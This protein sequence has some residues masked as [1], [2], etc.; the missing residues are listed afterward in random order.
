[1]AGRDTRTRWQG[2]FARHRQGCA[3]EQLPRK[4][5][6]GDV[7][8]VCSCKP[9][10]Y[11]KVYDRAQRRYVT[12]KRCFT[13][14]AARSARKTLLD[15]LEKGE[16]PQEAPQRLRDAHARFIAAAEEGRALNKHGRRYKRSAWEDIDECLTK[17]V[18]PT[19]GP[20][21]LADVRRADIQRLVDD[22]TPKMSGSR[23]RSI[24]NAIRSLYRWAQ[25]REL[26]AHDPA[27]RVR[28]P[29]MN[30][31]PR[32]RVATPKEFQA[33]LAALEIDDAL[34]YALAGYGM[35][36]RAQIQHLRWRDV[37][38]RVGAIEWGNE[39]EARK[40]SAARRVVPTVKPLLTLL[41]R[42]WI[43]QGRPPGDWLVCPPRRNTSTGLLHTGGPPTA[44]PRLG[45][46]TSFSQSDCMTVATPPR[47]GSMQ[48]ASRPR[49][50]RYSWATRSLTISPEPH[51]SLSRVT[52]TSCQMPW[53]LPGR[54]STA[55]LRRSS[56]RLRRPAD[57]SAPTF[58]RLSAL[59]AGGS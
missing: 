43:G 53:R 16:L 50:P 26:V 45:R 47:R 5:E 58:A 6:L 2:V 27:A 30:A 1:M 44:P 14:A 54:N 9:S 4:P 25:D 51:T 35:G 13:V 8:R 3:V 19:L 32:D 57:W 36:R 15:V 22:L 10:F 52:P 11:G 20:H 7:T 39:Q 28:L 31:T 24:V 55:G 21:R 12:T 37:D 41:K 38:L 29:A 40:S 18:M 42:A 23:V 34:P 17:H 33:L 59:C 56:P 49:S 46:Q 48:P